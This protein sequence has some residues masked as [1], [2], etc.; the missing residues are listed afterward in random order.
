[1]EL[2]DHVWRFEL[3]RDADDHEG[4]HTHFLC[5]NCGGVSCVTGLCENGG[6]AGRQFTPVGEVTEV[7]L[8]GHC[9]GCQ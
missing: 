5:V 9:K 4:D 8:K 2:G 1:M 7:L 6:F 3:R